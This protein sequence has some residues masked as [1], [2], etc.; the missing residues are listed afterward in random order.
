MEGVITVNRLTELTKRDIYELFRDGYT[1]NDFFM[2]EQIKYPYYGRLEERQFLERIYDLENIKSNDPRYMNAKAD[3][4]QHTISNDDYPYCWVFQDD[5]FELNKGTD[6]TYLRFICE[7]FDPVVR[8]EKKEWKEFLER[9]NDLIRADGYELYIKGY[10]SGRAKYDYRL[11]G[12]KVADMMDKDAVKDLIDEFKS[13]LIAKAT[14]GD[15]SEKDYKRFRDTLLN[16]QEL[17][18]SIP[19]FIKSNHT[20][21]DFRSYMQAYNPHYADR[22]A[23]IN[24]EMDG[25]AECLVGENDPFMQMSEYTKLEELGSGGFGTVHKYH[26]NC[27]DMDFA[28]KVYE[29][30]F[31]SKEEQSEGEK[32]FF[33]EA[34]MLFSLNNIHIARIYDAGRIDGKPYIRMEYIKGYTVEKLRERE[35]NMTFARS[36]I[37]IFHILL[38]LKHAHEHGVI[39]RDLRPRNI[40]FSEQER[41][42]KIIDFG[43]SAFLDADNHTQLTKTGEH[44]AGGSFIDPLLQQNPK[45]RDV[46]SDIY[47]VGA[48]W[49]FLLSGRAPSGSDMR[50]YLKQSN[51]QL[52]DSNVDIVMKCLSSN[53]D[54]R[55]G[56]CEE[57]LP[58]VKNAASRG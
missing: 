11:F 18:N 16:I 54:N 25:L 31:V 56:S 8:D 12:A 49:Y 29:P 52:T 4:I 35:G 37:V 24:S 2:P 33:R 6:E 13:G 26:N 48:I 23:L 57:L 1:V 45:M 30:V 17:K 53:I 14:N 51:S 47:S 39:H 3:I 7:I 34:K 44:I 22:R 46:R 41:I 36:A 19:Q 38:G 50:E 20:A 43:V 58:I 42:F 55:Y 15:I 10:I 27:L 21:S 28:V 40:I 9:V 5:R 32:R